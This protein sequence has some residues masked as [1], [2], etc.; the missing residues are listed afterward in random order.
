[1]PDE[2]VPSDPNKPGSQTTEFKITAAVIVVVS[3][4][5]GL[6]EM[7]NQLRTA[8]PEHRWIQSS[9]TVVAALLSVA[10]MVM[11]FTGSRTAVKVGQLQLEAAKTLSDANLVP[12]RPPSP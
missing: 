7:L 4:L 9:V 11:K 5:A 10:A 3:V 8:F 1:M 2:H 6:A 12:P